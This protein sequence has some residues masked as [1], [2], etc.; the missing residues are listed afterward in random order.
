MLTRRHFLLNASACILA[1]TA[2]LAENESTHLN[3]AEFDRKRILAAAD[4]Y[5][6]EPP[7]TVTAKRATRSTGDEHD[8][9]SEGDYWWPDPDNPTG[10]YIRKDGF[11]NPDNFNDHR[12]ALIRLSLIVPALV[13][14]WNLTK[15]DAY[16]KQAVAHLRAWFITP[17]TRMNPNLEHAQAIQGVSAGRGIG[18]IDTLQLVEVVR[19]ASFLTISDLLGAE[20]KAALKKW[21][22]DYLTWL[23]ESKNGMLERDEKNNHGTCWTLQ[24]AEFARF[25]KNDAIITFCR[26]QFREKLIRQMN[27]DGAFPLEL[28]RAKPYSYSL[29]NLDVMATTCEVLSTP[30]EK[31]WDYQL[32]DGRGMRSAIAFMYPYIESKAKWPYKAD[33]EYFRDLPVRS[34]SLIFAARALQRPEYLTLWKRLNPDP[35]VPEIIRNYPIRQPALWTIPVPV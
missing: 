6:N 27:F 2:I 5:L 14:A 34:P 31:L 15:N 4:K 35:T 13:A 7:M 10:P 19:A 20:D 1:P 33:V 21:F 12:D 22:A 29:F 17:A 8:Y 30:F 26:H 24:A 23:T 25:T 11:S 32:A 16:A 28:A 18:V 9:F 3:V